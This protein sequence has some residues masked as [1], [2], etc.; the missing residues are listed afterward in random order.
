MD[1]VENGR[2]ADRRPRSQTEQPSADHVDD[3]G[4]DT[5]FIAPAALS[6]ALPLFVDTGSLGAGPHRVSAAACG[7]GCRA[8]L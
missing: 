3:P 5:S 4:T 6:Q 8:K 1:G 7:R 2:W